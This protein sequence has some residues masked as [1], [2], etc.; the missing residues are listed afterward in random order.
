[1]ALNAPKSTLFAGEF[2][3]GIDPKNRITIPSGW[4]SGEGDEFFL[5]LDST[6]SFIFALP[7][8]EYR[9]ILVDLESQTAAS[10]RERQQ[11]IRQFSGGSRECSA[12][13]QGRMV[14]PPDLC[15]KIGLKGE[16]VLVG[17]LGRFEIWS[18]ERWEATKLAEAATYQNLAAQLGL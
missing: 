2:R 13:K 9:K 16:A 6:G 11:F 3:H 4:R 14:L 1:M 12:D 8:E 7:P 18:P 10:P 15:E 5:R 17:T